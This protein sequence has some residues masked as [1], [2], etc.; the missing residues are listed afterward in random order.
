MVRVRF[1]GRLA[2]NLGLK[3]VEVERASTL[4]ELLEGLRKILGERVN[5][6][7]DERGS[8]RP[9]VLVLINGEAAVFRGGLDAK[10]GSED[11]VV[12]DTIDIYEVEGG[13]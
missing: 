3:E 2:D 10:L 7:V 9:G 12:F 1:Y 8:L 6:I 13:G 4:K 5:A 11:S